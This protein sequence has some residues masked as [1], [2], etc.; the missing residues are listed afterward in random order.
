MPK[1]NFI[2][3]CYLFHF[4]YYA[5]KLFFINKSNIQMKNHLDYKNLNIK[6]ADFEDINSD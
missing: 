4:I 1:S 2:W 6:Y 3:Y 5:K